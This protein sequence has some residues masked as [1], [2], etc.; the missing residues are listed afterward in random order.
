MLQSSDCT[1]AAIPDNSKWDRDARYACIIF[2]ALGFVFTVSEI[3]DGYDRSSACVA[4][5]MFALAFLVRYFSPAA[6][7]KR[8]LQHP[9]NAIGRL[10]QV[11]YWAA[12]AFAVLLCIGGV[13][14]LGD[15]E[16]Q[17]PFILAGMFWLGGRSILYV[18]AGR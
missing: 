15:A 12:S 8:Q 11:L 14:S 9:L 6:I 18:L 2:L 3:K 5:A 10:G 7:L 17:M 13:V 4:L 1:Q 16:P